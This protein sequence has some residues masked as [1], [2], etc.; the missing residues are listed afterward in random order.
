[1]SKILLLSTYFLD[2]PSANGICAGNIAKELQRI[3]HEIYVVCYKSENDNYQF[4]E[5]RYYTIDRIR[6]RELSSFKKI[7]YKTSKIIKLILGSS[8]SLL[9][10]ELV[11]NYYRM[12]DEICTYRLI[13]V[14]IAV[15]FPL[16]T[17]QA[18][19]QFKKRNPEIKALVFELD[20]I[21][22]GVA[23]SLFQ[24]F[25]NRVYNNWLKKVY[26][27]IDSIIIMQSHQDYWMRVFGQRFSDKLGISDIP[28]LSEKHK[29]KYDN[30]AQVSMLYAGLIEK[31]YRSPSYLLSIVRE[32][33]KTLEFNFTFYSKGDCE[34]EIAKV[35]VD[36]EGIEQKGYVSN[37]ELEQCILN[38][39]FLISIG[40][41]VSRSVPS[42]II[43]YMSFGKPIIHFSS[44]IDD[45][46]KN[47]FNR[48][49]LALV[50]DQ[51]MSIG[52]ACN[53]IS[54]FIDN[55][56]GETVDYIT[57][58]SMFYLNDPSYSANLICNLTGIS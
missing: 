10:N 35:A 36:V 20:S 34:N 17:V 39:D 24:S 16:E 47:Y 56:R 2:N 14:I 57:V 19:S 45:V 41:S 52:D 30:L 13:D 26:R 33:K 25:F 6:P 58:Q 12:I 40:N 54:D 49:P 50:I 53:R 37:E 42:K 38:A 32:L 18:L 11:D 31:K 23:R 27:I 55:K 48:Y 46:C 28:V 43:T 21:G 5:E 44:Q 29:S 15:T 22:D 9:D 3:G 1:M 51:K 7:K 8:S 4:N